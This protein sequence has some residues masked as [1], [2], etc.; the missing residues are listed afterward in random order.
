[1][2]FKTDQHPAIVTEHFAILTAIWILASN[3]ELPEMSYK[4]L[5]QRLHPAGHI[6]VH[7]LVADH[8]EL[9]RLAIPTSRL[10]KIKESYHQGKQ[11]PAW[12]RELPENNR[13]T[14]ID[15]LTV[16]DFFRSQFRAAPEAPRS[17]IEI[18]D[19]GLKHIDRLRMVE[20][21]K[22]EIRIRK[23]STIWIP[24]FSMMVAV[25]AIGSSMYVQRQTNAD[26]RALK[27]YEVSFRPKVD[28]YTRLMLAISTSFER[29]SG[30]GALGLRQSLNEID[31]AAIQLEPFLK[32][33]TRD[34][35]K[36]Q[37]QMFIGFCLELGKGHPTET[38]VSDRDID[39]FLSCR[40]AMRA[41]L[42]D[43]LF[44]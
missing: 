29:A 12:L 1:L 2:K 25:A 28:G 10:K 19:W 21:E 22:R 38:K 34:S 31:L 41:T 17:T 24:L 44:Q 15:Q 8:R 26:Q 9:F 13:V 32:A 18:L 35:L 37:T 27:E 14:A 40:N 4:G 16:D 36:A 30:P 23:W 33:N 39:R 43:A 5:Y 11:L 6:D 42:Y 7:Q 3:D 20:V